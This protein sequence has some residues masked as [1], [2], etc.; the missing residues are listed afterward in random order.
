MFLIILQLCL[1]GFLFSTASD[2]TQVR[3]AE[4]Y[5]TP[6]PAPNPEC[7]RDKPCH[8]LNEYAQNSSSFFNNQSSIVLLFL[9]GRH[10]LTSCDLLISKI[11]FINFTGAVSNFNMLKL[12]VVI[13]IDW[14]IRLVNASAVHM[15]NVVIISSQP[16]TT[17]ALEIIDVAEFTCYQVTIFLGP[18][19]SLYLQNVRAV[20]ISGSRFADGFVIYRL[21]VTEFTNN[22]LYTD[23]EGFILENQSHTKRLH[24]T[25]NN[26]T[27]T[28]CTFSNSAIQILLYTNESILGVTLHNITISP[29]SASNR[30]DFG[31]DIQ[32]SGYESLVVLNIAHSNISYN[33]SGGVSV[34][35]TNQSVMDVCIQD[36][37]FN[38]NDIQVHTDQSVIIFSI[39]RCQLLKSM[40]DFTTGFYTK[41]FVTIEDSWITHGSSVNGVC[42]HF[43]VQENAEADIR[44]NKCTIS[45]C[46]SAGLSLRLFERSLFDISIQESEIAHC[47]VGIDREFYGD[48]WRLNLTIR[49]ANISWNNLAGIK[50]TPNAVESVESATMAYTNVRIQNSYCTF[51]SNTGVSL[52][53]D[54]ANNKNV[55]HSLFMKSVRFIHNQVTSQELPTIRVVGFIN[56]SIDDCMFTDNLGT[57]IELS[58]GNLF[59]SGNTTFANNTGFQG[60][61]LSLIYSQLHLA[62]NTLITFQNNLAIDVGGAMYI[63]K[64]PA[65]Q[66]PI[67]CFYQVPKNTNITTLK[68]IL[69]FGSNKAGRGGDQIYG[70][71]LHDNCVI[72]EVCSDTSCN[73]VDEFEKYFHFDQTASNFSRVSSD[74]ERVCLCNSN[75]EP[76]CASIDYILPIPEE[77]FPGEKF[78]VSAVVVGN[79]FGTLSG[80]VYAS[81]LYGHS[82]TLG[83]LEDSQ[84]VSYYQCNNLTYSLHSQGS[85]GMVLKVTQAATEAY[86]DIYNIGNGL[87]RYK[88]TKVIPVSLLTTPV[89]IN[90]SLLECPLGFKINGDPPSCNCNTLLKENGIHN[91]TIQDHKASIYR[92]DSQWV[93]EFLVDNETVMMVTKY[94]PLDY[95]KPE[96]LPISLNDSDKQCANGHSGM[97]CGAC[98]ENF[99]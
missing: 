22:W 34:Y 69:L 78:N 6:T 70:A 57:P 80:T 67:E 52:Q 85:V 28:N 53:M 26:F 54:S 18:R 84:T 43:L 14:I 86:G 16:Y 38:G 42:A 48:H 20:N 8:T 15:H 62:N 5:V 29:L 65:P 93:G 31:L 81:F 37:V 51:E 72:E 23:T 4:Y 47:W 96:M 7:P 88:E 40:I 24:H 39:V 66:S 1:C 50:L 55:I 46:R 92:S 59:V 25:H 61:A 12:Q 49:E 91:F 17:N 60:G 94:C 45:H 2:P 77:R 76:M 27:L 13:Q 68:I 36:S 30:Y 97:L 44:I 71:A 56:V 35:V 11:D 87:R 98:R 82:S 74:P 3:V 75:G 19:C 73:S 83:I 32:A 21:N 64:L 90:I 95:C 89:F 79:E 9:N 58:Y 10:N 99:S 63:Q 33:P 41:S